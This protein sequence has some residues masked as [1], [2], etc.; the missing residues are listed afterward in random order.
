[1]SLDASARSCQ[2]N[3]LDNQQKSKRMQRE[4]KERLDAAEMKCAMARS[5]L[6]AMQQ[7]VDSS[8][9]SVHAQQS[10]LGR[11]EDDLQTVLA[12]REDSRASK[13]A[14]RREALQQERAEAKRIATIKAAA[15]GR[16]AREGANVAAE[17]LRKAEVI[18]EAT[19]MEESTAKARMETESKSLEASSR[20]AREVAR[21]PRLLKAKERL[22]A[23]SAIL[24]RYERE[25]TAAQNE[26][27]AAQQDL[28]MLRSELERIVRATEQLFSERGE[29][30][31]AVQVPPPARAWPRSPRQPDL[32]I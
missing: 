12:K 9:E 27:R 2:Q 8:V 30:T 25:R 19:E 13:L 28:Q 11:K 22:S 29:A 24:S 21:E 7:K 26:E 16:A 23:A 18:L 5:R 3:E 6:T 32:E 15:D 4:L 1:M 31:E 10:D 20:R 17:R 14:V